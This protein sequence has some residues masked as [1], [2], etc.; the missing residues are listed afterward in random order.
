MLQSNLPYL[1][2]VVSVSFHEALFSKVQ[3][4]ISI[5]NECAEMTSSNIKE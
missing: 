2:V 4:V 1:L 3:V 5:E